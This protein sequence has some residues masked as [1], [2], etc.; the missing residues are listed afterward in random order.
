MVVDF[1]PCRAIQDFARPP[2]ASLL[3]STSDFEQRKSRGLCI[4]CG[5]ALM[6]EKVRFSFGA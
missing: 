5:L 6:H 2:N 3:V 4:V 1:D